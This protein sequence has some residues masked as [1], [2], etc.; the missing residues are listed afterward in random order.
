MREDSKRGDL[1]RDVL[2]LRKPLKDLVES[3]QE[4]PTPLRPYAEKEEQS[5]V[6]WDN[7]DSP[8]WTGEWSNGVSD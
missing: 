8:P 2:A 7:S 6:R 1:E 5:H 3:L 4:K